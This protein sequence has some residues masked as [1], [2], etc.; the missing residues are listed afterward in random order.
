MGV[1]LTGTHN[2]FLGDNYKVEIIDKSGGGS[3]LF[4]FSGD[5]YDITPVGEPRNPHKVFNPSQCSFTMQVDPSNSAHN[6]FVDDLKNAPE[7]RFYIKA[8]HNGFLDFAGP[9]KM[10]AVNYQD[11]P[12]VYDFTI[13]ASDG[14]SGTSG[15]DYSDDGTAYTGRATY[16]EHIINVLQKLGVDD[17]YGGDDAVTIVVNWYAD[18]MPNIGIDNPWDMSNVEHELFIERGEDG[19]P[20]FMK[21]MEVLHILLQPWHACLRYGQGRYWIEQIGERVEATFVGWTY[22]LDGTLRQIQTFNLDSLVEQNKANWKN[23]KFSMRDRN[24]NFLPALREVQVNYTFDEEYTP[25]SKDVS[26]NAGTSGETCG[27]QTSVGNH[28]DNIIIRVKG[29]L[30]MKTLIDPTEHTANG[31]KVHRYYFKMKIK[32]LTTASP[33]PAYTEYEREIDRASFYN[34]NTKEG[35]WGAEGESK[36]IDFASPAISEWNNGTNVYMPIVFETKALNVTVPT[37]IHQVCFVADGQRDVNGDL[38]DPLNY[39]LEWAFENVVVTVVDAEA[40]EG[41]AVQKTDKLK[42]VSNTDNTAVVKIDTILGDKRS[43]KNSILVYNGTEYVPP[44]NWGVG[45]AGTHDSILKLLMDEI[46]A[47]RTQPLEVANMNITGSGYTMLTTGRYI[48]NGKYFLFDIGTKNSQRNSMIGDYFGL[49]KVPT[50]SVK[51]NILIINKI[52]TFATRQADGGKID[53][54]PPPNEGISVI[55]AIIQEGD[56]VTALSIPAAT[57]NYFRTGDIV[58]VRDPGTGL[59]QKFTVSADVNQGD[60]SISV[61]STAA[62]VGLGEESKVIFDWAYESGQTYNETKE[63]YEFFSVDNANVSPG[64]TEL[65]ITQFALPPAATPIEQARKRLRIQRNGVFLRMIEDVSTYT[66]QQP[67]RVFSYNP[68]TSKILLHATTPVGTWDEF[69]CWAFEIVK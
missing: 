34:L 20:G 49:A 3:G 44:T 42:G 13:V 55:D 28:P 36:Y 39:D 2:S 9:V 31:F 40:G 46:L 56:T 8:Y 62:L 69:D 18:E 27:P 43:Q 67:L 10:D 59:K 57:Y 19:S 22:S 68:T 41:K 29:L 15:I 4:T 64:A 38:L 50:T 16:M 17:L 45:G 35:R 61:I 52:D 14:I 48:W 54:P 51:S 1:R 60:T 7:N 63:R 65:V 11:V 21:C 5:G 47:L 66:G 32:L 25:Y 58:E 12:Q 53:I 30:R 26:W 6:S 24:Y 23:S 33:G 37:T